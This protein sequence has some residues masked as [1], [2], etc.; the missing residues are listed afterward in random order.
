MKIEKSKIP[1]DERGAFYTPGI[2][3]KIS[4][5]KVLNYATVKKL[6]GNHNN[7]VAKLDILSGRLMFTSLGNPKHAANILFDYPIGG[8]DV[9]IK[10]N[11][12][13]ESIMIPIH[14]VPELTVRFCLG[15]K[16]EHTSNPEEIFVPQP[17]P[18]FISS[19]SNLYVIDKKV[20]SDNRSSVFHG[21]NSEKNIFDSIN[22][23]TRPN[24]SII[25][26][27]NN[28]VDVSNKTVFKYSAYAG[29]TL[30]GDPSYLYF[31]KIKM[32]GIK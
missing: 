13:M 16:V 14:I 12:I 7:P 22:E 8:Y 28:D 2:D 24:T 19:K 30:D 18:S 25:D 9:F 15:V 4:D 31:T 26:F 20:W 6:I 10:R 3:E 17:E 29:Y 32:K 11:K 5:T 23:Y 1:G 27:G 21:T